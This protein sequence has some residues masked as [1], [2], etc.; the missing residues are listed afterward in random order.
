MSPKALDLD[1]SDA[2]IAPGFA[3]EVR[4]GVLA[5]YGLVREP[6]TQVDPDAEEVLALLEGIE[7]SSPGDGGAP[8][9]ETSTPTIAEQLA[10][11]NRVMA[12]ETE[13]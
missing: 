9:S 4:D 3:N 12:A 6:P 8:R 1:S 2:L 10:F 11:V 13:R 7:L 5:E